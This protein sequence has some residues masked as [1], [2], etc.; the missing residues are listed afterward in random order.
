MH[1]MNFGTIAA[2]YAHVVQHARSKQDRPFGATCV[3]HTQ[4]PGAV[5]FK[6]LPARAASCAAIDQPQ[7]Q[8]NPPT[9]AQWGRH[10]GIG[11][12]MSKDIC[13]PFAAL[14]GL[15]R[16]PPPAR[17]RIEANDAGIIA[18][19]SPAASR[20]SPQPAPDRSHPNHTLA[21]RHKLQ[22]VDVYPQF[23]VPDPR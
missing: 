3:W 10:K 13:V 6:A 22:P 7:R 15:A 11:P 5:V 21:G 20:S 19:P 23:D 8:P 1:T 9:P 14:G 2:A 17:L 16:S 12:S 4:L 18:K